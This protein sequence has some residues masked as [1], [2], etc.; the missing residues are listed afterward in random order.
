[1]ATLADIPIEPVEPVAPDVAAETPIADD[2]LPPEVENL[3]VVQAV[4][5]GQP[6]AIFATAED[7]SPSIA[8]LA[9][10]APALPK[11]G[12]ALFSNKKIGVLYNPQ[13]VSTQEIAKAVR[14]GTIDTIAVPIDMFEGA[15][16]EI[17]GG[18]EQTALA[19]PSASGVPAPSPKAGQKITTARL[20]NLQP[21]TPTGGPKPGMGL[22]NDLLKPA[23]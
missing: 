8:V 6:P 10:A 9:K 1:M 7:K 2:L 3:P 12:L 21:T 4:A 23:I 11:A 20:K 13:I 15:V 16:A 22:L 5:L 18:G 17:Q 14:D 19:A